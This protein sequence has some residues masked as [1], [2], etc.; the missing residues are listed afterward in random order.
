MNTSFTG[1]VA[2]AFAKVGLEKMVWILVGVAALI[3]LV[4]ILKP[5]G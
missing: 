5:R 3:L 1:L 4:F 2:N